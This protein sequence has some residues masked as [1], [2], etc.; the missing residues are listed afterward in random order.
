MPKSAVLF[1]VSARPIGAGLTALLPKAFY[2]PMW[3]HQNAHLFVFTPPDAAVRFADGTR[4]SFSIATC[5]G[6][7]LETKR[8][9]T[10]PAVSKND[11]SFPTLD[12]VRQSLAVGFSKLRGKAGQPNKAVIFQDS[13]SS[14]MREQN[15][16]TKRTEFLRNESV[17]TAD[18]LQNQRDKSIS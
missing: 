14:G 16:Q 15:S 6:D 11:R 7:S 18:S 13:G 1:F 5:L 4:K 9:K 2:V 8:W 10:C 12:G 3:C 17:E